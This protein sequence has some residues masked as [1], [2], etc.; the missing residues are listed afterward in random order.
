[1]DNS[2]RSTDELLVAVRKQC[3]LVK[4]NGRG[5][6]KAGP[7]LKRFGA[8]VIEKGC[9]SIIFDMEDCCGMDSTFMGV[10]AGLALRLKND[11]KGRLIVIN[12]TP[13]TASLMRTLGINRLVDCYES[14]D[15][16]VTLKGCLS[17]LLDMSDLDTGSEDKRISLITMLEAHQNL[18]D[19]DPENQTRFRDVISFL[20]KD[21]KEMDG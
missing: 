20:D 5:T 10:V 2:T 4:V 19:I 12:L 7:S 8:S 11:T 21:L 9:T 17:H 6:F 3:A 1:M 13:K 15:I 16:P 14:G 18:A